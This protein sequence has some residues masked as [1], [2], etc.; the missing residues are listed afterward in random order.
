MAYWRLRGK[1]EGRKEGGNK[2]RKERRKLHIGLS[3]C[4]VSWR[5]RSLR[6][7]VKVGVG[8]LAMVRISGGDNGA[9]KGTVM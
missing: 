6:L 2:G 4:M 3:L 8:C 1:K 5:R 7:A 9:R